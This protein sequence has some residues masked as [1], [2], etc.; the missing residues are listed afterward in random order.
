MKNLSRALTVIA[1][2]AAL[3][4]CSKPQATEVK[5]L[6]SSTGIK[7]AAEGGSYTVTLTT[8]TPWMA[9]SN[10]SWLTVSP[11]TGNPSE[12]PQT[13][14]LKVE[15]NRKEART[16][17]V[18]F[19]AGTRFVVVNVEQETGVSPD[20]IETLTISEFN[21]RPADLN[22]WYRISGEIVSVVSYEYGD[23]YIMDDTGFAY[24]YGLAP[25]KDG[26]NEDFPKLG[27]K[28]GDKLTVVAHRKDYMLSSGDVIKETDKAYFEK[29]SAGTYPG[30]AAGSASAGWLELPATSDSDNLKYLCHMLPDGTRNFSSYFDEEKCLSLWCCYPYVNGQGGTG[31]SESYA[32]DPLVSDSFQGDVSATYYDKRINGEDYVRGHMIPSNDRSG[33][34][35]MDLF[36][37]TNIMPQSTTLNGASWNAMEQKIHKTWSKE[38]DTMYVVTGTFI[39]ESRNFVKD[40]GGVKKI[41]VPEGVYKAILAHTKTGQ[42]KCIAAYFENVKT[43]QT[44]F[45]KELAISVDS[46]E[47]KVG[48]DFFVN[49][50][51]DIEKSVE[52]EDPRN[53]I[54]WWN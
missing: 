48:V 32:Y 1:A 5:L 51:D 8:N 25:E 15:A 49:L 12:D 42:Y 54:F 11:S 20:G 36:L 2:F 29:S 16:A 24:I 23:L 35:N 19:N 40:K 47:N 6:I 22:A 13:I 21:A 53:D 7:A 31:R 50:P 10:F 34:A 27:L 14:T 41:S 39:G 38:C 17:T 28:A 43:T 4:S 30:Y 18:T 3:V 26:K 37:S 52:A 45:E 33:R 44:K 9:T 46:L